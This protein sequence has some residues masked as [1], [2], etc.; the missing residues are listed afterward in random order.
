MNPLFKLL[1]TGN[2]AGSGA[3]NSNGDTRAL[4]GRMIGAAAMGQSP[5]KFMQ[6]L[7]QTDD[8]FKGM[9][10]TNLEKTAAETCGREK[11]SLPDAIEKVKSGILK[12][13]R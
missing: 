3:K 6:N 12:F 7:A 9:D 2:N 8:R 4:I 13:K 1:D 10:F 11:I 5:E